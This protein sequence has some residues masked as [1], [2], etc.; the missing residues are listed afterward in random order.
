MISISG[1]PRLASLRSLP[2]RRS[3]N[4]ST[5][6]ALQDCNREQRLVWM[7]PASRCRRGVVVV[8]VVLMKYCDEVPKE[9]IGGRQNRLADLA[10][11]FTGSG[12][13]NV[14]GRWKKV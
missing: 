11:S 7:P 1:G 5:N 14:Q 10:S 4:Y 2:I 8:S 3:L 9:S 6:G 12:T 13:R